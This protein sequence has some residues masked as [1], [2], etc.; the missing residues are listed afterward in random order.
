MAPLRV[1]RHAEHR[2]IQRDL[3]RR[4]R[5]VRVDL[6]DRV[7]VVLDVTGGDADVTAGHADREEEVAPDLEGDAE[8]RPRSAG[9]VLGHVA[10]LLPA[11]VEH[12][13]V[14]RAERGLDRRHDRRLVVGREGELRRDP[15]KR[16]SDQI[17][18]EKVVEELIVTHDAAHRQRRHIRLRVLLDGHAGD[19][20]A[21][22]MAS[23]V[24][25]PR[26][27]DEAV[28]ELAEGVGVL[29][30]LSH[31]V[32][33]L[34]VARRCPRVAV[35]HEGLAD[36]RVADGQLEADAAE[37]VGIEH[38]VPVPVVGDLDPIA[39]AIM[40]APRARRAGPGE[41]VERQL[42]LVD[43]IGR[44]RTGEDG[45][46]TQDEETEEAEERRKCQTLRHDALHMEA[47]PIPRGR[48]SSTAV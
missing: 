17:E 5:G 33:V 42:A 30:A 37:A 20:A 38:E 21:H 7:A 26:V 13:R 23:E 48:G 27:A 12:E 8:G 19:V 43:E 40:D 11:G 1:P 6:V 24:R 10:E 35:R 16:L 36:A 45:G 46:G 47:E 3:L 22:G 39:G 31:I 4:E 41:R 34:A 25:A 29:H 32:A 44:R 28:E 2:G 14:G 15:G 9:D 18:V